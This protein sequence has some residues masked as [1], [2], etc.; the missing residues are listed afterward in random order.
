MKFSSEKLE[1]NN[2]LKYITDLYSHVSDFKKIC[3][4]RTNVEND[5]NG[6]WLPNATVFW[7]GG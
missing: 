2:T 6:N 7:L 5:E 4:P 1:T 3:Q